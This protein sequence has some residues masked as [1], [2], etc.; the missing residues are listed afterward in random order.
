MLSNIENKVIKKRWE[1]RTQKFSFIQSTFK[2]E[3]TNMHIVLKNC[4]QLD[5]N[6]IKEYIYIIHTQN[7]I[8]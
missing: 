5:F 7:K 3:K 8:I 6:N 4:S 1:I 2:I